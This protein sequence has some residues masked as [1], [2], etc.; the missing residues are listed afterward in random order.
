MHQL[1]RVLL[2]MDAFNSYFF[3]RAIGVF[4]V[5][6][7]LDF[8]L[9]HDGVV[10]LRNLVALRQIGVEIIFAVKARPAVDLRIDRHAGAH[11]LT[12]AFA[13]DDGQHAGK[14]GIDEADLAVGFGAEIGGRA[15]EQLGM[16][17]D[18]GM[19][20][21]ALRPADLFAHLAEL[22]PEDL[23]AVIRRSAAGLSRPPLTAD[24]VL[25]KL[26]EVGLGE[27]ATHLRPFMP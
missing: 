14:T 18:L 8:A 23:A 22:Y 1:T 9:T 5:E 7:N 15:A 13:V 19:N 17:D 16:A 21:T 20:C 25:D 10:E 12:H 11:G 2:D 6:R 4:F 24:E 27:M 3:G 26:A